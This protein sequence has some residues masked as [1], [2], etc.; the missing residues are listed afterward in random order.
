M[1]WECT[2]RIVFDIADEENI[3]YVHA[4]SDTYTTHNLSQMDMEKSSI[5]TNL[6]EAR[7]YIWSKCLCRFL[8]YRSF[9]YPN[10]FGVAGAWTET[11]E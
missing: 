8:Q 5:C 1:P 6:M 7:R 4:F 11:T 9:P 3:M 10:L 2:G